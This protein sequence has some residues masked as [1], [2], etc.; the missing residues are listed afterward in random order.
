MIINNDIKE[1]IYSKC[2]FAT[3]LSKERIFSNIDHISHVI[4][5][6]IELISIDYTGVYFIKNE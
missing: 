6:N 3:M 1:N 5:N 2:A 4:N